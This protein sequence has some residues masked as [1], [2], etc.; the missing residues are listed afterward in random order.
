MLSNNK[1]ENEKEGF[2]YWGGGYP[3]EVN[4]EYS[5]TRLDPYLHS[6]KQFQN[7][8]LSECYWQQVGWGSLN[9]FNNFIKLEILSENITFEIQ[10]KY[11]SRNILQYINL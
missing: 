1:V 6:I 11:L 7:I 9:N 3:K 4:A 8:S 10:Y 5:L 2:D